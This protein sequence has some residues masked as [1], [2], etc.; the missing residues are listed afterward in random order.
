M[1]FKQTSVSECQSDGDQTSV[2]PS[3]SLLREDLDKVYALLFGFVGNGFQVALCNVS[4]LTTQKF[5]VLVPDLIVFAPWSVLL[6]LGEPCDSCKQDTQPSA[7]SACLLSCYVPSVPS[8]ITSPREARSRRDGE[9]LDA[10]GVVGAGRGLPEEQSRGTRDHPRPRQAA[11]RRRQPQA[12]CALWSSRNR[13]LQVH[14]FLAISAMVWSRLA[15]A[16]GRPRRRRL[17]SLRAM[18][19]HDLVSRL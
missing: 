9:A 7:A 14:L 15:A 2:A 16:S 11:E 4:W 19:A 10:Q 5:V 1:K 12:R 17:S 8:P 18:Q 6:D 13:V 3:E